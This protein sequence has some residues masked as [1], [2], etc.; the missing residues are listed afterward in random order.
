MT[1]VQTCALPICQRFFDEGEDFQFYTYAKLGGIILNEPGGVGWQ[2]FDA[3]VTH[4][5]EGRYQTGTPVV[6]HTLEGLVEKLPLDQAACRR[7]LEAYNAAV[8]PGRFD[9]TVRDGLATR[10]LTLPKS[11]WAQRLDTPPYTAWPVTGGITF[12]FGGLKIDKDTRVIGTDWKPIPGLYTC[13]EMVGGLFYD[14]YPAGLEHLH[15]VDEALA[16]RKS[17]RL[18]SSHSELSR[19]PSSA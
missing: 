7:V 13:G 3:K 14:N 17:T 8:T 6:A 1:G 18:N 19:M 5:L 9:P 12:T 2:I 15:R 11:N 16:D 10:G 4:L